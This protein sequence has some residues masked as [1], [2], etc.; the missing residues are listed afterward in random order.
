MLTEWLQ[1]I[2]EKKY[3]RVLYIG[4]LVPDAHK[5]PYDKSKK[6]TSIKQL[7]DM[8]DA[9]WK[10]AS[11]YNRSKFISGHLSFA[12]TLHVVQVFE[13]K[14][15]VV[16]SL[17]DRIRKDP[18]VIIEKEFTKKQLTMHL[19]W[20]ISMCYSF[21]INAAQLSLV[22]DDNLTIDDMFDMMKNTFQ[23]R[24]QKQFL[25]KFYKE[26]TELILL[27]YISITEGKR[28]EY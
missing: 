22:Q 18:R 16:L 23:A 5:G 3:I 24:E 12:T 11:V 2:A 25:P 7:E 14:E 1:P 20:S 15:K 27:K 10:Q 13:G 9:I 28:M 17:M 19:G 4:R 8:M 26:T 21:E 6:G